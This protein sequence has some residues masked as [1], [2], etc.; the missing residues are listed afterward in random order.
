LLVALVM[1][2]YGHDPFAWWLL[3]T[4]LGPRLGRL[5]LATVTDVDA[6]VEHDRQQ[7]QAGAE[8]ERQAETVRA[9][10][11]TQPSGP[12]GD[13]PRIPELLLAGRPAEALQRLAVE[14]GYDLLV[15]GTR[16]RASPR[17]CWGA[18][19]PRSPPTQGPGPA[20]R[21]RGLSV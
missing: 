8:L 4:L 5:A 3:G 19:R 9:W 6:S 15:V 1:G 16:G 17:S 14:R 12:G 11:S 7:A 21:R 13:G 18:R 2:R 10:L 20:R